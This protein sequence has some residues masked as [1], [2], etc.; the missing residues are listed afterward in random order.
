V[1]LRRRRFLGYAIVAAAAVVVLL[2][3]LIALG[4]LVIPTSPSSPVRITATEYTILEGTNS[5]GGYWFGPD[6]LSYPGFN[7]YPGNFTPGSTFGVPIALYNYD[8]QNHTVYSVAVN[9]PFK[10]V[11][12]NPPLPCVVPAGED[13]A[14]FEFTVSVPNS[15]GASLVLSVTIN[16]VSPA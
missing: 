11:G 6:S 15:P 10:F 5:S 16:T 9:P 3:V 7:G 12:S 13:S 1:K 4:Y 14:N 2:L 8:S